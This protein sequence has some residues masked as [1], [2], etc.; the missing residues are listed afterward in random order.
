[1]ATIGLDKLFYAPITEDER[2]EETYGTPKVLAKAMTADL[3]VEPGREVIGIA[4]LVITPG[5]KGFLHQ[6]DAHAVG[7]VL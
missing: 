1:M 4:V 3:T 2:G 6:E 7:D 5:V